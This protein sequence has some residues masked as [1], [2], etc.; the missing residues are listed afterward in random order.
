M[1]YVS[2]CTVANEG[3]IIM[4]AVDNASPPPPPAPPKAGAAAAV[5][6]AAFSF[7]PFLAFAAGAAAAAAAPCPSFSFGFL[8]ASPSPFFLRDFFP[9]ATA[10]A[11]AAAAAAA[12]AAAAKGEAVVVVVVEAG[13]SVDQMSSISGRYE[14][15]GARASKEAALTSV[16]PEGL[17]RGSGLPSMVGGGFFHP[18]SAGAGAGGA[19]GSVFGCVGVGGRSLRA[20]ES[21]QVITHPRRRGARG[22]PRRTGGV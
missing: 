3:G 13:G 19:W 5:A 15:A 14:S 20:V 18:D 4:E 22:G 12:F 16:M 7:F 2:R 6:A 8:A 9:A 21:Q 11:T 1:E 10:A 17:T